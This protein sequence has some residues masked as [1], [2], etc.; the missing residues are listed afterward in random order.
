LNISFP[1]TLVGST[2]PP[3]TITIG[4]EGTKELIVS[5]I[6]RSGPDCA[7]FHADCFDQGD[8]TGTPKTVDL[9]DSLEVPITFKPTSPG[10]KTCK[11]T[12][13]SNAPDNGTVA[14]TLRGKG[15]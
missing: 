2:S 8:A 7:M 11:V 14:V 15:K 13:T 9:S 3:E 12:V 4:N 6:E 1:E 5:S 10:D